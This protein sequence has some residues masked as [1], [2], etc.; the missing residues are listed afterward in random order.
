MNASSSIT[1]AYRGVVAPPDRRGP[2]RRTSGHPWTFLTSHARVLVCVA[3]DPGIRVRE[4]ASDVQLTERATQGILNDLVEAGYLERAKVGRR[5][6]YTVHPEVALRHP[7][8]SDHDVGE[9]LG[10]FTT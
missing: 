2:A 5:N 9:L 6:E 4:I 1:A 10:I 7:H 8:D 3:R